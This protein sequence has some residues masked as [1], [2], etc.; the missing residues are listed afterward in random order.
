MPFIGRIGFWLL[1]FCFL[2][3]G[4]GSSPAH[5]AEKSSRNLHRSAN[6][7]RVLSNG[8]NTGA[9]Q[10]VKTEPRSSSATS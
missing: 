8:T 3:F 6:E 5:K 9:Y 7:K 4:H 1:G 10:C 2:S